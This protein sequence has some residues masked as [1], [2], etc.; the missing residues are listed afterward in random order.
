[1]PEELAAL[2][3]KHSFWNIDSV[4]IT[5][6]VYTIK[7]DSSCVSQSYDMDGPKATTLV[8]TQVNGNGPLID[9]I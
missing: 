8:K 7:L 2:R 9:F 4:L 1:M 3:L 5:F 6:N